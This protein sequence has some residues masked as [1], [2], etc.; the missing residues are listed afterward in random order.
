MP[1]LLTMLDRLFRDRWQSGYPDKKHCLGARILAQPKSFWPKWHWV[2]NCLFPTSASVEPLVFNFRFVSSM[3]DILL[4]STYQATVHCFPLIWLFAT[5]GSCGLNL[6]P[7]S[8]KVLV[9]NLYWHVSKRNS[10]ILVFLPAGKLLWREVSY[11]VRPGSWTFT[12]LHSDE[13]N[14]IV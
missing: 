4:S 5:H 10:Y 3:C 6:K 9:N 7:M 14:E 1:G 11:Q 2:S 12:W 13:S 8:T